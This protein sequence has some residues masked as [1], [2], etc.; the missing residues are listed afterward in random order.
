MRG[1][2]PLSLARGL[3]IT[4]MVATTALIAGCADKD[5]DLDLNAYVDTIES[6]DVLYNQALANLEAG[7]LKE[8]SKKFEAIDRQ[9][10]YTE[11]A[12]KALVMGAFTNYRQANYDEAVNMARRYISLYPTSQEAAYAYYIIGLAY[13]RQI[14]DV[15]RD[16]KDTKRAVAAMQELVDRYPNS[17]YVADAKDKIRFGREQLA[18]KEMQV[19]R[20]Y[21]ERHQYLAAI[22]RFKTVVQEYSNTNQIEEALYRLVEAN[23]ALGIIPEA[24]TAAAV[25]AQNYPDSKWYAD[26]YKLLQKAG[27][28]P[29]ENT[30]SWISRAFKGG[31]SNNANQANRT[32]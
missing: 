16:Q 2:K 5:K 29:Q 24:Q 22:N 6:P 31:S 15:T 21:L 32:Q 13:F 27:H 20:F 18:G 10:P 17:E 14:P 1:F 19:G 30:G 3:L 12:R 4:S 26:A 25:L 11:W 8:A 9:H 7:R 28:S 23:F